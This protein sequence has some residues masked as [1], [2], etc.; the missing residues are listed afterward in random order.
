METVRRRWLA[1]FDPTRSIPLYIIG[2]AALTLALQAAYDLANDPRHFQGGYW[3]AGA[4]VAVAL[5]ILAYS[6]IR[7]PA[8]GQVSIQEE[9][10]PAPRQGLILLVGPTEAAA[11]H[12]I[13]Y[14]LP[15]LK[16]CWLI[17]TAESQPIAAALAKRYGDRVRMVY[18]SPDYV[19]HPDEMKS[20]YD[21]VTK[22]IKEAVDAMAGLPAGALIADF[23]GGL[24]PM[25]A[26]MTLAC[27][28]HN[29][30][31]QYMKAPRN[32]QGQVIPGA[33]PEPIRI[34]TTFFPTV[35][36]PAS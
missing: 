9:H 14:H 10:K 6:A 12:A 21:G 7:R 25:T 36:L 31:L 1:F 30:D 20:T 18:G 32:A 3:L 11:P 27:L 33:V 16:Q 26:G 24:K 34:D 19:V 2:T 29:T 22:A 13:E 28:A 4:A 17:A 15:A 23:T 5:V 35:S 8:V